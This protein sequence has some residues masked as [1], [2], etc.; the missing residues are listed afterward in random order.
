MAADWE[1]GAEEAEAGASAASAETGASSE[2]A[3]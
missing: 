2:A 1:T 3:D